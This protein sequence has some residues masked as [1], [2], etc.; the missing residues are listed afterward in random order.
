[1]EKVAEALFSEAQIEFLKGMIRADAS[2]AA[3][4]TAANTVRIVFNDVPSRYEVE[5]MLQKH[6]SNLHAFVD[7]SDV[8]IRRYASR[9]DDLSKLE[10]GFATLTSTMQAQV[11]FGAETRVDVNTAQT[12]IGELT[13]A[14]A[15][16]VSEHRALQSLI[17]GNPSSPEIP[18]LTSQ[19]SERSR[20]TDEQHEEIKKML[21]E[22]IKPMLTRANQRLLEVELF[23]AAQRQWLKRGQAAVKF[24]ANN[25]RWIGAALGSGFLGAAGLKLL[26]V[27]GQWLK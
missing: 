14:M 23:I 27:I 11:Q 24:L 1:M 17:F 5:Q 13:Q 9:L 8:Y 12:Q 18:S 19:L 21:T 25:P 7:E 22:D 6:K 10:V 26:E 15:T 2:V 3:E 20:R 4:V 16:L